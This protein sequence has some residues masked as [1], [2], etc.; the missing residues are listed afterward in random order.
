MPSRVRFVPQI[1]AEMLA[2]K[3]D[4]ALRFEHPHV[5]DELYDHPDRSELLWALQWISE[6]DKVF[7]IPPPPC[8]RDLA[9]FCEAFLDR[10]GAEAGTATMRRLGSV[11]S[12]TPEQAKL[13][14][15]ELPW[16]AREH[17]L[18]PSASL[19]SEAY[20]DRVSEPENPRELEQVLTTTLTPDALRAHCLEAA[21]ASLAQDLKATCEL[22][23]VGLLWNPKAHG[24]GAP[25][26]F[27]DVAD[28]LIRFIDH[29]RKQVRQQVAETTLSRAVWRECER[30]RA[31]S[32][33]IKLYGN[34]RRGKTVSA[35]LLVKLFPSR[36]RIVTTPDSASLI[37]LL[38]AVAQAYGII[39]ERHCTEQ[40][41]RDRIDYVRRFSR[42]TLI[43]D[44]SHYLAPSKFTRSTAPVRLNWLRSALIDRGT[45]V[46]LIATEQS[47]HSAMM[48]FTKVTNYAME[49]FDGRV[50]TVKLAPKLSREDMLAIGRK[51]FVG[52]PEPTW[53]GAILRTTASGLM[54]ASDIK[55]IATFAWQFAR[56]GG[57]SLPTFADVQEAMVRVLPGA[58][59]STVSDVPTAAI[60]TAAQP[61]KRP[62]AASLQRRCTPTAAPAKPPC[63]TFETPARF[64]RGN[65]AVAG[66]T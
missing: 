46:V 63:T 39:L 15:N 1:N 42:M 47:Y 2:E 37:D 10:C 7:V 13:I 55:D 34:P 31:M 8:F 25:W 21:R 66:M 60:S 53:K 65:L 33:S 12:Y 6:P 41:L 51:Y 52:V 61:A 40:T 30:A 11:R 35:E 59:G 48:R 56:E 64:A 49:Q 19:V 45:P 18:W 9:C 3:I 44:E 62:K 28:S 23:H 58:P 43:L 27:A 54:R 29:C 57:R 24:E 5:F 50:P 4:K 22:P 36:F 38:R 14:L 20:L 26:Y 32:S 16:H 17:L